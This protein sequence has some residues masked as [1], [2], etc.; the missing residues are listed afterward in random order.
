MSLVQC[1]SH[2]SWGLPVFVSVEEQEPGRV[3]R[4]MLGVFQF[5]CIAERTVKR[6]KKSAICKLIS[7]KI[8]QCM[9]NSKK[10]LPNPLALLNQDLGKRKTH[11]L[12]Y[13]H[14]FFFKWQCKTMFFWV[15][16][17]GPLPWNP[18]TA[19]LLE[20]RLL[21]KCNTEIAMLPKPTASITQL[22]KMWQ[23]TM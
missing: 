1:K 7:T 13:S 5:L 6:K 21:Q 8:F 3:L 2:L 16:N 12:L 15:S 10:L 23:K 14:C 9:A 19:P 18:R 22:V 20:L 17:Y 11:Q 4:V